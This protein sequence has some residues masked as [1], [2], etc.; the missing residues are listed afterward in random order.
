MS[1]AIHIIS[2]ESAT[3]RRAFMAAQAEA[4]HFEPV[5]FAAINGSC[6]SDEEHTQKAFDWK[7]PLQKN[8]IACFLSHLNLWR[9]VAEGDAPV[10]ILEDDVLLAPDWFRTVQ[11]LAQFDGADLINLEAVG[12]KLIGSPIDFDGLKLRRLFL[13]SSGAGAYML[14]PKGARK[15]LEHFSNNGIA[16]ADAFINETPRLIVWQITPAICIQECMFSYYGLQ[17]SQK[18]HS[19]IAREQHQYP[20]PPSRLVALKMKFRRVAGELKIAFAKL[21]ILRG[22]QRVYVSYL[23][24]HRYR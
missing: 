20:S 12:K 9:Q 18:L 21:K 24:Y 7:R 23:T 10:V 6:I 17:S 22:Y 3:Q 1:V 13:N 11:K 5:W 4:L 14:W 16:L 2:L 19:E 8:E 15:L